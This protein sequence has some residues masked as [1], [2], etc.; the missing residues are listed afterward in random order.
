MW[1]RILGAAGAGIG[2]LLLILLLVITGPPIARPVAAPVRAWLVQAV[3]QRL[4]DGIDG[5][6]ELGVLEGS[7]LRAPRL[8]GVSVRDHTG[9]AVVRMEAVRLHYAP[10]SLLH[11]GLV[12]HDVEVLRPFVTL[13]QASDGSLNLARLFH[14]ASQPGN[15]PAERGGSFKLPVGFELGGLRVTGGRCRLALGF[16]KGVT[17]ISDVQVTLAGRA[18]DTGL[19]LTIQNFAAQTH[20]AQVNLTAL[21]GAVH[22]TATELRVEHLQLQTGNTQAEFDAL[23]SRGAEPLQITAGLNP[24]DVDEVGRLIGRDTLRG[25]LHADVQARGPLEDIGL[26]ARLSAGAGHVSLVGRLNTAENPPLYGGRVNVQGLDLAALAD[27]EPL[28]SDINLVLDFKGRGLSPRT[29]EGQLNVSVK[30]SYLGDITLDASRIAIAAKSER[31]HVEAFELV[32]SFASVNASGSLDFRGASD[33]AYEA[34]ADLSQ[35]QQLIGIESLRGTLHLRGSAVGVWPDLDGA[36]R[37]TATDVRLGDSGLELLDLDYQASQLGALPQASARLQVKGLAVGELPVGTVQLQATYEGSR[38]QLAFTAQQSHPPKL[39]SNLGGRLTLGDTFKRA[40]IDTVEVRFGERTWRASTPLDLA[41]G[42]GAFNIRSFRLNQGEESISLTGRIENQSLH[43]VRL[44]ASSIDLTYLKE[45]LG[46]PQA[47]AGRASLTVQ[48]AGLFSEPVFQGK[49]RVTPLPEEELPFDR[50]QA[51]L[52]YE[53][54][55]LKGHFSARQ[56]EREVLQSRFHA[57]LDLTLADIPVPKRLLDG[58]LSL[59][60]RLDQPE[61]ASLRDIM[62]APALS[63]ALGAEVSVHGTYAQM[64]LGS[65]FDL[66][67]VSAEG[68][69]EEVFAVVGMTAVLESAATVSLL[70]EAL[71]SSEPTL[72]VRRLELQTGPASGRLAGAGPDRMLRA[73]E[74]ANAGLKA[75]GI[76]NG[77]GIEATIDDFGA[78]INVSDL[79]AMTL[80]AS[81]HLTGSRLELRH[82]QVATPESRVKANGHMTLTDR[83]FQLALEVPRLNLGEVDGLLPAFLAREVNG[84]ARLE[85]SPTEL[86]LE[87]RMRYGEADVQAEGS[88]DLQH[89]AYSADVTLGGLAID[90]FLPLG[91]GTLNASLS[92]QGRGF[93]AADRQVDLGITFISDEFN[94]APGLSGVVR[95]ALSGSAV[96]LDELRIDS[97]PLQVTAAGTLSTN[98]EL[99]ASYQI[100]LGDLTPLGPLLGTPIQASGGLAGSVDGVL[101]ALR[102][103]CELRLGAWSIGEFQGED[104]EATL[105]G[106]QLPTGPKAT[107]TASLAGVRGRALPASSVSLD[108]QYE[109]RLA[110]IDIA[111]NDG[112]YQ[113][114]GINGRVDL[115]ENQI[116]SLDTLRL[117]YQHWSW[118]NTDPVRLVR[119]A[120]G[121]ILLQDFRLRYGEQSIQAIGSLHPSGPLA[122]SILLHQVEIEPWL[123][124]LLP[125]VSASGRASLELDVAG[126]MDSPEAAGVLQLRDLAWKALPFGEIRVASSF[127]DGRLD[128]HLQWLDGDREILEVKGVLGLGSD[129]PLQL[130]ARS[131]SLDL[132]MLAPVFDAV[133]QSGG[134]LDFQLNAGGTVGAPDINGE[135]AVREGALRLASTQEPYQDIE[136]QLTLSNSRLDLRSLTASSS[137]GTLR[138]TGWLEADQL[139]LKHLYLS[140]QARDFRLMNTAAV[141]GRVTGAIEAQGPLHALTVKGDVT[142]PRARIRLDDFAAGP[143]AVSPADLTLSGVYGGDPEEEAGVRKQDEVDSDSPVVRG[144]RTE[145]AV[146]L[147]RNVWVVGPETAVE[148]RG[149][150]LVNKSANEPFVIGG[151]AQTVRGYVTYRGR[152]FDLERG[153]V[154][155]SGADKNKP[156]LDV[157]A[158]HE[159]S[160]YVI[161]L[162]VEGDSKRPE[163]TFSSTP[164]LAE[165]DIL[166]LLAFGKTIDRLSG[167]ER[168]ALSS[169][170]AAIAGNIISGILEKRL[171]DTLGLDT[172]EVEVGDELGTGS[173]RG[174]RYITQDL[175]LSYERHLGEQSGNTVEVE[176]SLGPRVKLKGASDDQGQSSLDLFWHIEY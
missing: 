59:S 119:Q 95:A 77:G 167:S 50:V 136:A 45:K 152:K 146:M 30:P 127:K 161:T 6:L 74:V 38:R 128:N 170:G 3:A 140:L 101:D 125:G 104:V 33:L 105:E 120:D 26:R 68:L 114:T 176:Y 153:R 47:V 54:R 25:K 79:P 66:R 174:G 106:N 7:L 60:L 164:E 84:G 8:S 156:I 10:L 37:L 173:V 145:V 121:A 5:T 22:A 166:S 118:Q 80:S 40:V 160:D 172:L 55:E 65:K 82:L 150:L 76:W 133:E 4:S 78:A 112:P 70:A 53:S 18:D 85:G 93:A 129:Y 2:L 111:V 15:S 91:A 1:R 63:G 108:A 32:S 58:P 87:A 29:L 169:Q 131:S 110:Q 115:Q 139:R 43:G 99:Q 117:H 109:D 86:A 35:L 94:L 51:T 144:L 23:L 159:V 62:P 12:I 107:L 168:T 147:P 154:M 165:E 83:R 89:S 96:S 163:L 158:R 98:R 143:V 130:T 73:V 57:P 90:G 148:I 88:I 113:R 13:T 49:I 138:G 122:A 92:M 64:Q 69:F 81:A 20:P 116:V 44:E 151:N 48:A 71:A 137:T 171:G 149:T 126:R 100:I 36:G 67:N 157:V 102:A 16:L 72:S 39:E 123:R 11:G 134:F 61:L 56:G 14:P 142:I 75:H 42:S 31:I 34:T 28:K 9:V 135:L 52:R 46:L 141:Q 132:A 155:F 175:F 162:H 21:Q 124:A 19:H 97:A 27:R 17:A 41:M 103:R 24:L